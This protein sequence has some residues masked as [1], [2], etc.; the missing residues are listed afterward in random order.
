MK[1]HEI[2]QI[3][4]LML[5][6]GLTWT[7]LWARMKAGTFPVPI[8]H[9]TNQIC[10]IRTEINNWEEF[11]EEPSDS[12]KYYV[13]WVGRNPGIYDNW[14]MVKKQVFG[15]IRPEFKRFDSIEEAEQAYLDGY[16]KYRKF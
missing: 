12:G 9:E 4:E 10:W 14:S 5:Q 11:I 3:D 16:I 1:K 2:I 8:Y 6:T 13:V 15:E 7:S